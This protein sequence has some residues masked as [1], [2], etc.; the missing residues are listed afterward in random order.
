[1][2][3]NNDYTVWRSILFSLM[4]FLFLFNINNLLFAGVIRKQS[5]VDNKLLTVDE[6]CAIFDEISL[7]Y[8]RLGFLLGVDFECLST[9]SGT[10]KEKLNAVF[11]WAHTK[12]C[13]TVKRLWVAANNTIINDND[14]M[15]IAKA[16]KVPENFLAIIQLRQY[17][18]SQYNLNPDSLTNEQPSLTPRISQLLEQAQVSGEDR[19]IFVDYY[20][21]HGSLAEEELPVFD[22]VLTPRD[23]FLVTIKTS[24]I[25]IPFITLALKLPE[26]E[27]TGLLSKLYAAPSG[28]KDKPYIKCQYEMFSLLAKH[29]LLTIGRLL[30]AVR[31]QHEQEYQV[32]H[33]YPQSRDPSTY[34]L[35]CNAELPAREFEY[36]V[37]PGDKLQAL[38]QRLSLRDMFYF[39]PTSI[40]FGISKQNFAAALD[41]S[42]PFPYFKHP[43]EWKLWL[44]EHYFKQH[45]G[46][47]SVNDM[48]KILYQ[49]EIG[50]IATAHRLEERVTGKAISRN[51]LPPLET[52]GYMLRIKERMINL[53]Q[54]GRN[55]GIDESAISTMMQKR[56]DVGD[57]IS[58][59]LA[60]AQRLD[61]LTA[62]NLRYAF[63]NSGNGDQVD[64]VE[65]IKD[66]QSVCLPPEEP[67]YLSEE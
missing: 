15:T 4:C 11:Q 49:P 14:L 52:Y 37:C 47:V 41:V 35:H 32:Y 18:H 16:L 13:L 53:Q 50:L 64:S 54:I 26:E 5:G 12:G 43:T 28:T 20:D 36:K 17:Q 24:P 45:E 63:E 58:W 29:N 33:G 38:T 6:T 56:E 65:S 10:D 8:F 27:R 61:R 42:E 44:L 2:Q 21:Y 48:L 1:M 25:N 57:R 7:D 22:T 9:I 19:V 66:V 31:D 23:A 30:T 3:K 40:P 60:H 39:I 55:L 67:V 62:E 59:I 51:C 34:Y 46:I